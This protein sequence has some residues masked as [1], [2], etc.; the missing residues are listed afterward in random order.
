MARERRTQTALAS[1][2]D[3]GDQ[4]PGIRL[5]IGQAFFVGLSVGLFY[6]VAYTLLVLEFGSAGLRNVYVLVGVIIPVT[7]I[8]FNWLEERLRL[9]TFGTGIL[10]VFGLLIFALYPLVLLPDSGWVIY[11]MMVINTAGSLYCMMLRGA[12]VAQLYDARTIKSEYPRITGGEILAVVLAG[13][14]ITPLSQLL[15]S[16]EA[17]ILL[18]GFSMLVASA[19]VYRLG[20]KHLRHQEDLA[21][22]SEDRHIPH[23]L[24]YGLSALR[25]ILRKR[26]TLLVF[27]F[28]LV[29]SAASLLVQYI[30][31]S[32]AKQFFPAQEELSQFIGLVKA[33]TTGLSFLFL[34]FVAGRLL[35]RFGLPLG[36][37]GSPI[38]VGVMLV[39]ALLAGALEDGSGNAFF[40]LVVASQFIDYMLYSGFAKTTIQSTFQPLP[41]EEREAVHTFAQGI[42]IPLSYGITGILLVIFAQLPGFRTEFAIYM[43]LGVSGVSLVIGTKLYREYIA[44]LRKSLGRRRIEGIDVSPEDASTMAIV[45]RLLSSSDPWQISSALDILEQAQH[46]DYPAYLA[47]LIDHKNAEV[48][49]DAVERIEALKPAWAE[50]LLRERLSNETNETVLAAMIQ[51]VCAVVDEPVSQVYHWLEADSSKLRSAAVSGLFLYGGINGILEAGAIFNRLAGSN[52]ALERA[53]AAKI[54]EQVAIRNFYHPL[55]QLLDDSDERVIRAALRAARAVAHPA[56]IESVVPW[57]DPV[58]TRAEALTTLISFGSDV[59]PLLAACLDGSAAVSRETM[60]RIIRSCTRIESVEITRELEAALDHNNRDVAEAVYYTLAGRGYRATGATRDTVHRLLSRTC[61]EAAR[62]VMAMW[63]TSALDQTTALFGSLEDSY[64][65]HLEIIFQLLS[66][67]YDPDDVSA[68]RSRIIDGSPKERGLGLELLDVMLA[69]DLKKRVLALAEHREDSPPHT[70]R[71]GELFGVTKLLPHERIREILEDRVKWPEPW[72]RIC[73]HHAAWTIGLEPEKPEDTVLTTIERVIALKAA[74]IFAGIPDNILA[75]IA[76]IGEDVEVSADETFIRKGELG[77]CMYI[78]REGRVAIHD[79]TTRF[80]EL[81]AGEVVGEMAVLDPEPRSA[82]ATAIEE[83]MLLKI[84]KDAFDSVMV[85]HPGIARGVIQVLC[86]RLRNTIQKAG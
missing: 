28:Q 26:Y 66:F 63:E 81:P 13:V 41:T 36:V 59:R 44:A 21:E 58:S 50:E 48:R 40:I 34:V 24:G 70:D 15:G 77:S 67:V 69:G 46:S 16:L 80:A 68:A 82:S 79:E 75:H 42:G 62:I 54:L 4:K 37:A 52:D 27:T 32:E 7:T 51:A 85:D 31:Y 22:L 72:L 2:T 60:F 11:A 39:A 57:I 18:A 56:L 6:N 83:T 29:T 38:G 20:A 30:V 17:L 65:R 1:I 35:I 71:Y 23:A 43:T 33:G 64:H 47:Q 12:Q 3:H 14:L 5:L 9:S 19:F 74:D 49:R 78:I 25:A 61:E 10:L 76:S 55:V 53:D 8:G 86:R 45:E 73:A 84:E